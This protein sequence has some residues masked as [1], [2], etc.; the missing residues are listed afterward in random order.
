MDIELKRIAYH[1]RLD[2]QSFAA[3]LFINGEKAAA[4]NSR[5]GVTE[6][7]AVDAKGMELVEQA[8]QYVKKLPAEKKMIDGKEQQVKQ[9]L[10]G[11]IDKKFSE[12]LAAIEQKKFDNK[13]ALMEKRNIVIGE[14]GRY[15]RP[16]AA[17][18]LIEVLVRSGNQVMLKNILSKAIPTMSEKE[19]V[20]N[21]NIP[22]VILSAAGL[23][24]DQYLSAGKDK[25]NE[26]KKEAVRKGRQ[27]SN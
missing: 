26:T 6:Y 3:N 8:E 12:Y 25:A 27:I 2:E 5:A 20:L 23:K 17:K 22:E 21:T 18:A 16:I 15:M 13:V 14:P 7:Y 9:T 11:I 24:P 19:K 4:V 1:P 10:P